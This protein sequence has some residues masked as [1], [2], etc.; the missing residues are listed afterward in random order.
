MTV[1][2]P[3]SV[4]GGQSVNLIIADREIV[5]AKER[6]MCGAGSVVGVWQIGVRVRVHVTVAG[7]EQIG[8]SSKYGT[9][10]VRLWHGLIEAFFI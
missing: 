1:P 8:T 6:H 9:A 7:Y 4:G 5:I 10:A 2:V 3:M